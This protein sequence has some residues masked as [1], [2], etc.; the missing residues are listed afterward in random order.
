[1][2]I[3]L[4]KGGHIMGILDPEETKPLH[5]VELKDDMHSVLRVKIYLL[6]YHIFVYDFVLL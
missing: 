3:R 6:E 4:C 1:M 2:Y 5:R